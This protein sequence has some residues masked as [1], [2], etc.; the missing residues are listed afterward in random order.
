MMD[1]TRA[2]YHICAAEL[3]WRVQPLTRTGLDQ[4][5]Y[6]LCHSGNEWVLYPMVA[7]LWL[8]IAISRCASPALDIYTTTNI[9]ASL[10]Q[11]SVLA[12]ACAALCIG[13]RLA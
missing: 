13:A 11:Q 9:A 12:I 2:M 1:V 8:C 10:R 6:A 3:L 7:A 4:H 5:A